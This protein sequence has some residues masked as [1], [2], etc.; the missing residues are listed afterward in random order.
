MNEQSKPYIHHW[1]VYE[2]P[3]NFEQIFLASNP[4]P[5]P[6]KC[7][8]NTLPWLP[9]ERLCNRISLTWAVGG[10]LVRLFSALLS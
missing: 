1:I 2:C 8:D 10:D 3:S 4:I 5:E 6:K 7:T 9:V